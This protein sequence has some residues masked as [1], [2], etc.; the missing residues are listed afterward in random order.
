MSST[1]TTVGTVLDRV[2]AWSRRFV[3][4]VARKRTYANIA[5]LLLSFPLGIGYFTVLVTGA[6]IPIGLGFALADMA[7]TEPIALLIAGIPLLLVLV[8][9]G[10][11]L[12]AVVLF[13]SIELT[14]LERLLAT[15]LLGADVRTGEPAG[16]VRERARRL[17]F[18]RGTWKGIGYLFSKFV[19]GLLSFIAVITGF[20]FTYALV[21]APL[22]YRNQLVGIHIADPIEVVPELTYQHEDWTVDLTSPIPLSITDGEL[23]SVYV[24]SLPSA[25][26]VSAVGI[27]VGLVVLHLFNAVA[28]LFARYTELL[29]DGTQPSIFSEPPTE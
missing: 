9:I 23:V 22:H 24:D 17:V 6:A 15:R 27:L 20:A 14:A 25:L 11:P 18:D 26:V 7:T 29:L 1:R 28:W 16:S 21:A 5:Y 19:L 2:R 12:V 13:A 10:G 8:C 4:V 3:G